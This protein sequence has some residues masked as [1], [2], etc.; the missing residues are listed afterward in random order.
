MNPTKVKDLQF[1]RNALKKLSKEEIEDIEVF[2]YMEEQVFFIEAVH[3]DDGERYA[4]YVPFGFSEQIHPGDLLLV[5]QVVG[6]GKA[7]VKCKTFIMS[8]TKDDHIDK[9]HPYCKVLQKL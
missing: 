3:H 4:W 6:F 5:E 2:M 7:V 8:M 1:A 9:I